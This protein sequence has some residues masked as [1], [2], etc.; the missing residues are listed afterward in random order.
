MTGSAGAG[1][2]GSG[3]AIAA[4]MTTGMRVGGA[5]RTSACRMSESAFRL[6]ETQKNSP[7]HAATATTT[8]TQTGNLPREDR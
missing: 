8:A 6:L 3:W 1:G 4:R 2:G 7:P 5:A